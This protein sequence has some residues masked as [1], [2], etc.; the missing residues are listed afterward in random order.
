MTT[1]GV[2]GG[3]R[4]RRGVTLVELIV[5]ITV[6][7]VG[8]L[9]FVACAG[10][11]TRGLTNASSDTVAAMFGQ[12]AIEELAGTACLT[13]PLNTVT[14][15]VSRGITRRSIVRNNGNNTLAVLDSLSWKNRGTTRV[16]VL[17]TILPCRPGA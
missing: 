16:A 12:S 2:A 4:P 13:I 9:G 6:L 15:T 14:Q 3:S 10:Y 5:A 17:Q 7:S 1:S 8:I 11:L